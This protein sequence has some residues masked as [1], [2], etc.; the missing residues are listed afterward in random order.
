MLHPNVLSLHNLMCFVKITG[1][2]DEFYPLVARTGI[3]VLMETLM[4]AKM[5]AG[6]LFTSTL[7]TCTL[8]ALKIKAVVKFEV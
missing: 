8:L 7:T 5:A 4:E 2:H 3:F 1:Q 6:I